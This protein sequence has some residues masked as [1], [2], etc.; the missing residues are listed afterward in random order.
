[1][2]TLAAYHSRLHFKTVFFSQF[3]DG[4]LYLKTTVMYWTQ[5]TE[6]TCAMVKNSSVQ[7]SPFPK[8]CKKKQ[9]T[10][11][12]SRQVSHFTYWGALAEVSSIL[13]RASPLSLLR[14]FPCDTENIFTTY[15]ALF[16]TAN[17]LQ[18]CL[19]TPPYSDRPEQDFAFSFQWNENCPPLIIWAHEANL[20]QWP[21]QH[22]K[23]FRA[24]L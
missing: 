8:L 20:P 4:R 1:M 24:I 22:W 7:H 21:L 16:S 5:P 18:L 11:V 6:G 19:W 2:Y 9:K 14:L 13:P 10:K 23:T 3:L 17:S 12:L 15:V